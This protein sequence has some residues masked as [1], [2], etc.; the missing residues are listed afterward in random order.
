MLTRT[1]KFVLVSGTYLSAVNVLR[2]TRTWTGKQMLHFTLLG[3]NSRREITF[4]SKSFRC[5][6]V[7]R[8][9]QSYR[10]TVSG[11]ITSVTVPQRH[12]APSTT[13][14]DSTKHSEHNRIDSCRSS[15]HHGLSRPSSGRTNIISG[16][17]GSYPA[18]VTQV[19][20]VIKKSLHCSRTVQYWLYEGLHI[21]LC[22]F[23]ATLLP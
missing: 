2:C 16:N 10:N 13:S 22:M 17:F 8:K 3:A 19:S 23:M 14:P 11:S 12:S 7:T 5:Q 6:H 4:F 1:L 9:K 18:D 21:L 15:K 20:S